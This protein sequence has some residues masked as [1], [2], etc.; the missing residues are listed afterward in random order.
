MQP[1]DRERPGLRRRS[2]LRVGAGL[3]AGLALGA[4]A[5][6]ESV[7]TSVTGVVQTSN[8]PVIGLVEDGV[9]SF[10]GLR[11]GAPPVETLRFAPPRKP[12][13]WKT[14]A[15]AIR[16]GNPSMQLASGGA[17]VSYPGI[18]GIALNQGMSSQE[19]AVRQH[20]DCLF[21]NLWTPRIGGPA[22]R[23]VMVWLHGG[24]Y[25]YGSGNWPFYD[26]RN[27][28][29]GHDVVVVTV[30]HRLNAFGF[31]NVAE[32]GGDP[33]SGNAGMLDI[34][35]ALEWVRDNCAA[36]GG[37]PGCVT[38]FGQSGGGGK[39][40]TLQAMP[41]AHGLFHRAIIQSGPSL[42]VGEKAAAA[43]AT[44]ALM[45]RLG[46]SD[47][48][49][50]QAAP[51][52][53]ILAAAGG[54]RWGPI[55]DGAAIASHPFDP[56]ANPLSAKTPV[57][58]G[59]T[60]DEQTLYNVGFDWWG[61][62]TEAQLLDKLRPQ[63]GDKAEAAVAAARKL[64]PDDPPSYLFTDIT[65]KAMF[66]GSATLAERKS[67]QPGG[68]WLYVWEWRAPVAHGLLRA[69]H[70]MEIPFAFDNVDKAPILLG[71]AASTKALARSVSTI[72]TSFARSGDPN[73]PGMPHWPRYDPA[74]RATMMFNLKSRIENDPYADF[75]T[76]TPVSRG[77]FG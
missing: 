49:G 23:P 17:A 71:D 6:A 20:E 5:R 29:R 42:R 36:F 64:R 35:Q 25:N 50:L 52:D 59:C 3:G 54:I 19:D 57:M 75:R 45:A 53:A 22:T 12:A 26:G 60:A 65:S 55:L 7:A 9:Q 69:P 21:L 38:V 31:M 77:P 1:E 48:K 10:K 61:G 47:L 32:I 27:L 37:D 40:S 13:P 2:L 34:V 30:N 51:A 74:A 39:T 58:V 67:A 11:Y 15:A 76:L 70:T 68:A 33:A 66:T 14:P 4:A 28:A 24:G 44:A 72:W 41:G 43:Q 18:V 73:I 63:F 56:V 46:V 16:L 8:G 62:L